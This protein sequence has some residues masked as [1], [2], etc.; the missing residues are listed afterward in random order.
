MH[1]TRSQAENFAHLI[2]VRRFLDFS[3]R[4]TMDGLGL[5]LRAGDIHLSDEEVRIDCIKNPGTA[6]G[7]FVPKTLI[8]YQSGIH[9]P[10]MNL[11]QSLVHDAAL[12]NEMDR[13]FA[14]LTAR[15]ELDLSAFSRFI[16]CLKVAIG[17]DRQDGDV[18]RRART[19]LADA[20]KVHIEEHLESSLLSTRSILQHFG[21]S[22]ASLYRM[23][24]SV[25][26]VRQFI[27]DRRVYRAALD[28]GRGPLRRGEINA[29][30][31]RWG[32]SS[33]S[34]F[35]RAIKREFGVT[36]GSLVALPASLDD[37]M[38]FRHQ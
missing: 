31:E 19:A 15:N 17:S 37:E 14:G 25:G 27:N 30:S 1:R 8:G 28:I 18:R 26:G 35:N 7:M 20:I 9:A 3:A 34:S 2:F 29:I 36:P 6:Q 23:F 5:D 38:Q 11:S 33:G 4:A 32:F 22:R 10:Y 16:A 21:V 13:I 24:E 12:H